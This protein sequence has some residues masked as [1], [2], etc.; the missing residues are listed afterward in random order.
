MTVDDML[1]IIFSLGSIDPEIKI[2]IKSG[3][4][5]VFDERVVQKHRIETLNK[6]RDALKRNEDF[7]SLSSP[8]DARLLLPRLNKTRKLCYRKDD[9]AMRAI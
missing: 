2:K 7:F 4:L 3:R 6:N 1:I 9:R 8:D 5:L